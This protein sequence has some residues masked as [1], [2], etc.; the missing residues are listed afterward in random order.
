MKLRRGLMAFAIVILFS[1]PAYAQKTDVITLANGDRITGEITG[2]NKG[3][4]ELKTDDI[5][6]IAIEWDNIVQISSPRLFEV[7]TTD[8]RRVLGIL[9]MAGDRTIAVKDVTGAVTLRIPE[10]TRVSPI[11]AGFWSKLEGSLSSGFSYTRSSGIA[12]VNLNGDLLY[13]RPQTVVRLTGSATITA[14]EQDE[15]D[16]EDS[17]NDDRGA[18]EFSYARY[19]GAH[20]FI[21]GATRFETNQSLGLVLRSQAG[22]GVGRR[23][24]NTNK[25]QVELAGGLAGNDEQG[26]DTEATQNLEGLILFHSSYF[27]YDGPKTQVDLTFQYYPSLSNWGRQRIQL[28]SSFKRDIWKDLNGSVNFFLTFDSDP[29]NPN[30]ARSDLGVTFSLGWT[31]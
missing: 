27:S 18:T 22:G 1:A 12:Q 13:R 31:F 15:S 17:G 3:R 23:L 5:G 9:A 14:Q 29:P 26:V 4:L 2:L 11:G 8:G 19:R 21:I 30:A 28:D 25:A 20:W 10:I 24:K 6:T 7:E 16:A